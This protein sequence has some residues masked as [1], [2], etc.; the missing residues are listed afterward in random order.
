M[1]EPRERGLSPE[2]ECSKDFQT[3]W[4]HPLILQEKAKPHRGQVSGLLKV[5]KL[6]S[7]RAGIGIPPVLCLTVNSLAAEEAVGSYW[8]FSNRGEMGIS[9]PP[10]KVTN[11]SWDFPGV[12]NGRPS[13]SQETCPLSPPCLSS[14]SSSFPLPSFRH[15]WVQH[16]STKIL[17]S[18]EG[19][20][21]EPGG[22]GWRGPCSGQHLCP[23]HLGQIVLRASLS[24]F[25]YQPPLLVLFLKLKESCQIVKVSNVHRS[26]KKQ[27]NRTYVS[28]KVDCLRINPPPGLTSGHLAS[29]LISPIYLSRYSCIILHIKYAFSSKN[30]TVLSLCSLDFHL[31]T[32]E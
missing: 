16:L 10:A 22:R 12:S 31:T 8:R 30:G 2:S 11:S 32:Y 5:T 24:F 4:S 25:W 19:L 7:G 9:C 13:V 27:N 15:T 26:L 29:E 20:I 23:D 17:E 6:F 3:I 21:R 14:L 18:K 28:E 1:P